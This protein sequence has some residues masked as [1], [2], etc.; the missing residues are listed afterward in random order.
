[1]ANWPWFNIVT[2]LIAAYGAY[3]S[4]FNYLAQRRR[5]RRALKVEVDDLGDKGLFPPIFHVSA[6]N[7]G[8]R[9]VH[10]EDVAIF[11]KGGVEIVWTG[12]F[13][14][15]DGLPC[16]LKEG[17]KFT[18]N[19]MVNSLSDLLAEKGCKGRVKLRGQ[20]VDAAGNVYRSQ[21]HRYRM[22]KWMLGDGAALI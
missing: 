22:R 12:L 21:W 7:I 3:L 18:A 15:H 6:V 16:E 8:Y 11:L 9:S 2:A 19:I 17:K 14:T 5:D 20:F 4:T 1:M 10:L 13:T